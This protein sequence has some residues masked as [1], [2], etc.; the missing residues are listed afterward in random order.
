VTLA[1]AGHPPPLVRLP[2]RDTRPVAVTPGPLLGID[3]GADFP[4]TDIPLTP[5]S[6]FAFYTDGLIETPGTDLEDSIA[7]LARH[8]ADADDQ[9]LNLL[10][11][12]LLSKTRTTGQRTD[13]IA[14][15]VLHYPAAH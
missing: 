4:V 12:T 14:L 10:I 3:P 9:D 11:D 15:L 6:T 7:G 1:S 8:L 13:D 5:G 2:D